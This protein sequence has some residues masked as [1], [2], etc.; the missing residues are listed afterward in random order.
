MYTNHHTHTYK[1]NWDMPVQFCMSDRYRIF[2]RIRH[3][4]SGK[5]GPKLGGPVK[6]TYM[7]IRFETF[8][9]YQNFSIFVSF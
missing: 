1:Y 2:A 6:G 7:R 9:F 3:F 8:F 4:F 5:I